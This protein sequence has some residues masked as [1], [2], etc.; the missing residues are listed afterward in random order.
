MQSCGGRRGVRAEHSGK[1]L[2]YDKSKEHVLGCV[3]ACP[4]G[5]GLQGLNL[6]RVQPPDGSPSVG[7]STDVHTAAATA[8]SD[9]SFARSGVNLLNLI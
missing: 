2:A 5:P 8:I 1:T 9:H 7:V 3:D 6:A 4:G